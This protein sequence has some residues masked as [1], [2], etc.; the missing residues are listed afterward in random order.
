M[1]QLTDLFTRLKSLQDL[2]SE[3]V[4][5]KAGETNYIEFKRKAHPDTP[6]LDVNDKY[7]FSKALSSF[8]NAAG[9]IL[10]WGIGT[11]KRDGRDYAA[12]LE[13]IRQVDEF[14]ERL[15]DS[16]LNA[17]I[18]QNSDVRIETL[19]NRLGNG[20]VKC[21]IPPSEGGPY[22]AVLADREYWIRMDG[23]SARLEHYQIRD[24]MMRHAL[25][26]LQIK[27][28]ADRSDSSE[29]ITLN[30]WF[31]NS[32]KAVAKYAGWFAILENASIESAIR[33]TQNSLNPGMVCADY[34][35]TLGV[36]VHP[37]DI[38]HQTGSLV[39][40]PVDPS[41]PI[42]VKVK[43]Y[44]EDMTAKERNFQILLHEA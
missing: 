34:H 42:M 5:P 28:D 19:R 29:Q 21:L 2:K 38:N 31:I 13:H 44:C 24:M 17:L 12:R 32:G 27:V 1:D 3:F 25:P 23:R 16:L 41:A 18:P 14:A 10:I 22:R 37:N 15:R 43:W 7:N 4:T 35:S 26:D 30:F 6:T 8:S 40:K 39:V 20:F 33:C 9:G 36:V 11:R